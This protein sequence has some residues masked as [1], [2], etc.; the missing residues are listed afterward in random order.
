MVI[1]RMVKNGSILASAEK[2]VNGKEANGMTHF[3]FVRSYMKEAS[4]QSLCRA[5]SS[6]DWNTYC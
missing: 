2:M 3:D 4:L 5:L 1:E 6:I